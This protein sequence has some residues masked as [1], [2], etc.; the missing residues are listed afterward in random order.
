MPPMDA[1]QRLSDEINR[2]HLR[3]LE[4]CDRRCRAMP[5]PDGVML[6]YT[7]SG[8]LYF[9]LA[10]KVVE[11]SIATRVFASDTPYHRDKTVIG[12]ARTP[13][14]DP[15]ADRKHLEKIRRM[16]HSWVDFVRG[17]VET[18]RDF[19]SFQVDDT[20]RGDLCAPRI[21]G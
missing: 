6:R 16:L 9:Y 15:D 3:E 13:M 12:Q 7:L 10:T 4:H 21:D 19:F 14:F 20:A 5:M 8:S 18:D 11:G 1:E 2:A 17:D